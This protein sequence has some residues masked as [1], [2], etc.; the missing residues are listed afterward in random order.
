M[1][2]TWCI[3][4]GQAPA[5]RN[6]HIRL[7]LSWPLAW[8]LVPTQTCVGGGGLRWGPSALWVDSSLWA[9]HHGIASVGGSSW[10]PLGS[11][12]GLL[13]WGAPALCSPAW[14]GR[15]WCPGSWALPGCP[16]AI[17]GPARGSHCPLLCQV[18]PPAGLFVQLGQWLQQLPRHPELVCGDAGESDGGWEQGALWPGGSA[19]AWP[20]CAWAKRS[21]GCG[22]GP[23]SPTCRG[24]HGPHT[25]CSGCLS[26]LNV[27]RGLRRVV[28]EAF[29]L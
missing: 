8:V 5:L 22:G 28:W 1:R 12:A 23:C 9:R 27:R 16:P 2:Q 4:A 10:R 17:N 14:W 19:F 21:Y 24:S 29:V 6:V 15:L 3:E 11:E 25:G 7:G 13:A 26:L 18:P 20:Q